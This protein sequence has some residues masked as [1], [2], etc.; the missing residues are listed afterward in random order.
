MHPFR[1]VAL[2]F[3]ITATDKPNDGPWYSRPKRVAVEICRQRSRHEQP[4]GV[5]IYWRL[6]R[7]DGATIKHRSA[8]RY[9][10]SADGRTHTARDA[11]PKTAR[12]LRGGGRGEYTPGGMVAT[13]GRMAVKH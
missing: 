3:W 11:R 9:A 1:C 4:P 8:P 7:V 10:A 2:D 5:R 6:T 12:S 13:A